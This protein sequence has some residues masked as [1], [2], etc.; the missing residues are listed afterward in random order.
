MAYI[1]QNVL[2]SHRTQQLPIRKFTGQGIDGLVSALRQTS[3]QFIGVSLHLTEDGRVAALAFATTSEVFH[4]SLPANAA[5]AGTNKRAGRSKS[6]PSTSSIP[7]V[8]T[9]IHCQLHKTLVGFSMARIAL[10]LFR[11]QGWHT[12]GVDLSS[13]LISPLERT[14]YPSEFVERKVT[15][16]AKRGV[17]D[18]LWYPDNDD[19]DIIDKVCQ[20]A[21][22]SAVC[23]NECLSAVQS[24]VRVDTQVGGLRSEHLTCL[25]NMILCAELLEAQKPIRVENDFGAIMTESDGLVL[26]NTRFKTRVRASNQTSVVF[27]T[28]NGEIVT[29][30]AVTTNGKRTR[31]QVMEGQYRGGITSVSVQGREELTCAENAREEFVLRILQGKSKLRDRMFIDLLWF[32]TANSARAGTPV[33]PAPPRTKLFMGLN[34]SQR[35]VAAAMVSPFEPLVIAHGPPGT[36]KTTTI[37]AAV[38]H[39]VSEGGPAWVVAQSNV[40]V[41]NI[42]RSLV[43][44]GVTDFKLIVSKEFYV[45]WHEDLYKE[46]QDNII[47]S[48]DLSKVKDAYETERFLLGSRI[49][50]C[51][52]STLSNPL[53]DS[54]WVHKIVPVEKLIVDE[55]S[56]INVFEFMH[57]FHKFKQLEKVCFFG[58]PKQLPPFGQDAVRQLQSIFDVKHLKLAAYF[59][60]IQ[61]RMPT[62]LGNFISHEVYNSKLKSEHKIHDY[63]CVAFINAAKGQEAACGKSWTVRECNCS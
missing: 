20:R 14:L 61:Y 12:N 55:A 16:S 38:D 3:A 28:D 40:G 41:K 27:E 24:A 44:K 15:K 57:L 17:I 10:H 43:S 29:G 60:N 11:D 34:K 49:I 36:G 37:A 21:W 25:A 18:A 30:Q 31:I 59:L 54:C 48:D 45:E 58:D 9:T 7:A 5:V 23:A 8:T 39:W 13:L 19:E 63:S 2:P 42:A 32:P 6:T 4:V 47:R 33:H 1:N 46:I 51:T 35:E 26:Q 52:L 22:I 50:L 53:L 56:Q 62:P